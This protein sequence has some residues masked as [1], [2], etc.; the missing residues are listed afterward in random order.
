MSPVPEPKKRRTKIPEMEREYWRR[1]FFDELYSRPRVRNLI[2]QDLRPLWR[3]RD[4]GFDVPSDWREAAQVLDDLASGALL[5]P[6]I[7]AFRARLDAIVCDTLRCRESGKA[8]PW[9]RAYLIAAVME[10]LPDGPF[11]PD[12]SEPPA[13]EAY[14]RPLWDTFTVWPNGEPSPLFETQIIVQVGPFGSNVMIDLLDNSTARLL[15]KPLNLEDKDNS[16]RWDN[17]DQLRKASH[18][19]LDVCLKRMQT[20]YERRNPKKVNVSADRDLYEDVKQLV[21]YLLERK[22]IPDR[23]QLERLRRRSRLLRLDFPVAD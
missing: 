14:V 4:R 19:A 1:V 12:P 11:L 20:E 23:A 9:V 5:L 6:G 8:S 16:G 10:A 13:D 22:S 17:W 15:F 21:A 7:P 3:D 2:A 18:A